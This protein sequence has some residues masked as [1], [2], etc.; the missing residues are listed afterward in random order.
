MIAGG[1]SGSET[2]V[3]VVVPARNEGADIG[4]CLD[5]ILCQDIAH[6]RVDVIVVDD[7]STDGTVGRSI[8]ALESSDLGRWSVVE[9]QGGGSIPAALD[10]GLE[11]AL[12]EYLVRV[13]ARS[14]IPTDYVRRCVDLLAEDPH[15]SVVGG[16]QVAVARDTSARSVGI[17][18][19]LN[20]RW[21]M[22]LSRYRRGSASGST[23]TVYLGAFRTAQLREA[24]GWDERF[25]VNEDFELNRRL[26]R[27][28]TIWF[29]SGLDV[30]YLPRRTLRQLFLQYRR[31]GGGKVHYWQTTGD[32]PRPRQ[33]VLL[34]AP[35]VLLA[36][37]GA[38]VLRRPRALRLLAPLG[39]LALLGVETAGTAR[40]A[41]GVL[42]RLHGAAA[43]TVVGS[44]WT[45][46]VW[47]AVVRSL[48][49]GAG[50]TR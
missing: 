3:S 26:G 38:T 21:G 9:S 44:G 1:G 14:I 30:G 15:K 5:A 23:D 12:G 17:A 8:A 11:A 10:T 36:A 34:M 25:A 18:R 31:F 27:S 24:G 35:V 16:A 32:R 4:R 39:V 47:T 43:L 2:D 40:P 7:G 50:A 46:G 13:D 6:A 41:G 22:G 28:G 37:V 42:A 45:L 29:E 49:T 20:N 33:W 48:R 19:A